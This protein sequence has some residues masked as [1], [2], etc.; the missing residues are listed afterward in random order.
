MRQVSKVWNMKATPWLRLRGWTKLDSE[1]KVV[2]FLKVFQALKT[3][4]GSPFGQF[5]L[6]LWKIK[7]ETIYDF[8]C[9]LGSGMTGLSLTAL[10]PNAAHLEAFLQRDVHAKI[11][12]LLHKASNLT[13][14]SVQTDYE[15]EIAGFLHLILPPTFP[16]LGRLVI[17]FSH[18]ELNHRNHLL[19]TILTR[20]PALRSLDI[21][22]PE[23]NG[24]EILE[25]VVSLLQN[26]KFGQLS[27]S[28]WI[29]YLSL[30][31]LN[32]LMRSGIDFTALELHIVNSYEE[33]LQEALHGWLA[34][35]S[36]CLERL[37]L[38]TNFPVR[39]TVRAWR[40]PVLRKMEMLSILVNGR[41]EVEGMEGA[42]PA[43]PP[44]QPFEPTQFPGMTTFAF[45][46]SG[47]GLSLFDAGIFSKI[48]T[49]GFSGMN[50]NFP[51]LMSHLPN[52]EHI[53]LC[54]VK[55]PHVETI[56][57]QMTSIVEMVLL[58]TRPEDRKLDLWDTLTCRAV[59][60]WD[61]LFDSIFNNSEEGMDVSWE[62]LERANDIAEP[63]PNAS[64]FETLFSNSLDILNSGSGTLI[65][66][67]L[68][69]FLPS[70]S[71]EEKKS[72]TPS[73]ENMKSMGMDLCNISLSLESVSSIFSSRFRIFEIGWDQRFQFPGHCLHDSSPETPISQVLN[74]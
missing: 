11:A 47:A 67:L 58:F 29:S 51:N 17:K 12:V 21:A 38:N 71:K 60:F 46:H 62:L 68:E 1:E 66:N 20:A 35:Q 25:K 28:I 42:P 18:S 69:T 72:Q 48:T 5:A 57:T 19:S 44:I 7:G 34:S 63:E 31:A 6:D 56:L 49:I 41:A 73:L 14:L 22:L 50:G 52:L 59:R 4:N 26:R 16:S 3:K 64:I 24:D 27:L 65:N 45:V 74:H 8:S 37:K 39:S 61:Q 55:I 43:I 54:G 33:D 30:Q 23:E 40:L 10:G 15:I 9:S 53:T 32:Q 36:H 2:A 70:P 13:F